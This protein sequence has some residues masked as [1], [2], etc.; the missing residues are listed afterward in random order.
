MLAPEEF[1]LHDQAAAIALVFALLGIMLWVLRRN[2]AATFVTT[3]GR[4]R[5]EKRLRI[6]ERLPLTAQNALFLVEADG[7]QWLVGSS[8]SGMTV[9]GLTKS[10]AE[11]P[12][13]SETEEEDDLS[14]Q[15]RDAMQRFEEAR[16]ASASTRGAHARF[17]TQMT[18]A[19]YFE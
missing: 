1:L 5:P 12:E 8:S 16:R 19:A 10:K 15:L 13:D 18:G 9:R 2:G 7:A 3:F 4:S 14:H 17:R 11:E 6:I